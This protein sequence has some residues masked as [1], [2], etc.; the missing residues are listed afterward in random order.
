MYRTILPAE[1][2]FIHNPEFMDILCQLFS[3]PL[4]VGRQHNLKLKKRK[5]HQKEMQENAVLIVLTVS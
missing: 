4:Q 3:Y 5:T 1:F 2:N